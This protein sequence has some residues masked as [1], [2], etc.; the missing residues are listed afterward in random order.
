[1]KG[2]NKNTEN[3]TNNQQIVINSKENNSIV[4]NSSNDINYLPMN[5]MQYSPFYNINI[6]KREQIHNNIHDL[7]NN[8]DITKMSKNEID[9]SKV[10][11]VIPFSKS[12]KKKTEYYHDSDESDSEEM[13]WS[14]NFSR[15][16]IPPPF[17][18]DYSTPILIFHQ[19]KNS[20]SSLAYYNSANFRK[21]SLLKEVYNITTLVSCVERTHYQ[22]K[23]YLNC[24]MNNVEYEKVIFDIISHTDNFNQEEMIIRICNCIKFI[25]NKIITK[26]ET[27]LIHAASGTQRSS[28]LIY[29]L[30]RLNNEHKD[31]AR[32][33][34]ER[35]KR[36]SR[37]IIGD[38]SLEFAEKY[39]VPILL[40]KNDTISGN[41]NTNNANLAITFNNNIMNRNN[42]GN[43][44]VVDSKDNENNIK[45][46]Q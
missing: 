6:K 16:Y 33:I 23:I 22:E 5:K 3:N 26:K 40:R 39:L 20:E 13:E 1:M 34:V 7:K 46:I 35:L 2:K 28:M 29:C 10:N 12:S 31:S 38:Y 9:L 19:F 8:M 44:A 43:S 36:L 21:L 41:K 27:V 37:N 11:N 4:K 32:E 15:K 25:Y 42:F 14:C 30:M 17:K 18:I 24:Y 45:S